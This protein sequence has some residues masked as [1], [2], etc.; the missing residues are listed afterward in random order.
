MERD[1]VAAEYLRRGVKTLDCMIYY[2][3]IMVLLNH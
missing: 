2:F 1:E 3:F